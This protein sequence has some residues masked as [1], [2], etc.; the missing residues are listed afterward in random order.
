V[1]ESSCSDNH[2]LYRA[3]TATFVHPFGDQTLA[4]GTRVARRTSCALGPTS[5]RQN[6]CT[7]AY[8]DGRLRGESELSRVEDEIASLLLAIELDAECG[9][10]RTRDHYEQLQELKALWHRQARLEEGI[11]IEKVRR[12]AVESNFI[13]TPTVCQDLGERP[14]CS[15]DISNFRLTRR[16]GC[17]GQWI[18]INCSMNPTFRT[19]KR[20][21][22]CRADLPS[23]NEERYSTTL[24]HAETGK[25]WAQHAVG[26][27][28]CTGLGV[29]QYFEASLRWF[30]LAAWQGHIDSLLRVSY[31]LVCPNL[32]TVNG[33]GP[34]V[35]LGLTVNML[36]CIAAY[37]LLSAETR[38]SLCN[39][40]RSLPL[41]AIPGHKGNWGDGFWKV[42][43]NR[44][45][46][47][48]S[49]PTIGSRRQPCDCIAQ[50]HMASLLL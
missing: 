19:F 5:W 9:Y 8:H 30:T 43:A 1:R 4:G 48:S 39:G 10:G 11:R 49:K 38:P 47:R 46:L 42:K 3:R 28:L 36:R 14:L 7:E 22:F 20:C 21:P 23:K 25:V 27:F 50:G 24:V 16:S 29:E 31:A 45:R 2:S 17:C 12:H 35:Q 40:L 34:C 18:C 41:K 33:N 13:I 15:E 32:P 44:S 6:G 26:T 37:F